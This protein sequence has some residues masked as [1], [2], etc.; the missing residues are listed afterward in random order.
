VCWWA[1]RVV[2]GFEGVH[3]SVGAHSKKQLLVKDSGADA[4]G[5]CT[6]GL[7]GQALLHFHFA[8][9]PKYPE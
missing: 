7:P 6:A 3:Q 2:P 9:F 1:A 4:Y 5:A 8:R